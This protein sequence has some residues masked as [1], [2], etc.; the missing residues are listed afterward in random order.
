MMTLPRVDTANR[1]L[2]LIDTFSFNRLNILPW[3][4]LLFAEIYWG[5]EGGS[6]L[7]NHLQCKATSILTLLYMYVWFMQLTGLSHWKTGFITTEVI[8]Q[9]FRFVPGRET[10]LLRGFSCCRDP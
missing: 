3:V 4:G 1:K 9:V 8:L 6:G 5:G 2:R 7:N 10:V